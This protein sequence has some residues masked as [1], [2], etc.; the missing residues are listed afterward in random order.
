MQAQ[1]RLPRGQKR[2]PLPSY[3]HK[4][5]REAVQRDAVR[6]NSS[7]SWIV[8]TALAAFYDI[9]IIA[10]YESKKKGKAA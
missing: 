6:W 10:P 9:D 4:K 3:V 8:A 7:R 5:I 1:S 2:L